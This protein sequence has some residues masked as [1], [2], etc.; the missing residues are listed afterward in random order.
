M[1]KR[2]L[3]KKEQT[4]ILSFLKP[5]DKLPSETAME[6][7][8]HF[9]KDILE[10]LQN[11]KIYPNKIPELKQ[12]I[13]DTFYDSL[14]EP[15][16]S[17]GVLKAQSIGE[18][19]TQSNLN[20]FHTAGSS[21][22]AR[23]NITSKF[24]ELLNTT[25]E[26]K[27]PLCY[28]YF[29]EG[30]NNIS[31]LRE[32]IGNKIVE[33]D[34][35]SVINNMTVYIDK[36]EDLWYK[37]FFILYPEKPEF[38]LKDCI[39]LQM[40]MDRLYTYKITLQYI[41]MFINDKY[42]DIF[43]I[44]SP[45]SIGII[46]IYIDTKNVSLP[47]NRISYINTANAS[48]I[49]LEEVVYPII[50]SQIICGLEGINEVYFLKDKETDKWMVETNGSNFQKLLSLDIIDNTR[51]RTTNL[52]DIYKILGIE[53]VRQFLIDEFLS[54]MGGI[55]EVHPTLL[56]DK[57]TFTGTILSISR[58]TMRKEELATFQ[59]ISFEETLDNFLKSAVFAQ[60]E[61]TLGV[62]ASIICG[63]RSRIGSGLCDV[64]LD[65]EK[66]MKIIPE[67]DVN[68]IMPDDSDSE[69]D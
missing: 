36:R 45:D 22:N 58:Y 67:D 49:Y 26:P 11:V 46:N 40:N 9:K 62:S 17:V 43:V 7:I 18:K 41:A 60:I 14:V 6:I 33:I 28:I 23:T 25:K 59:Q 61:P 20:S 53:A 12:Q 35:K 64:K 30:N 50:N 39:S 68:D 15:G 21:E 42:N 51:T 24:S 29:K 31:Q 16:E 8:N 47:E 66:I 19:Q 48:E 52:W 3:T 56:A 13:I 5:N 1:S 37:S 63:K 4:D 69:N 54:I 27:A 65:I 34:M 32:T 57:M 44:F 55:N 38:E 10:Q 2:K